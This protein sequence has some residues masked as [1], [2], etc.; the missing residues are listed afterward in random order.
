[1]GRFYGD[2]AVLYCKHLA[3]SIIV[4]NNDESRITAVIVLSDKSPVLFANVYMPTDYGDSDSLKTTLIYVPHYVYFS[5][6]LCI[7]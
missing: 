1:V 6:R 4:V 5:L 2:T 7:W 3:H